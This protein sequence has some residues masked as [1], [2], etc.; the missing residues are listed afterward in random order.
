MAIVNQYNFEFEKMDFK[1]YFLHGNLEGTIYMKQY[2]GF[3]KHKSKVCLPKENQL[4]IVV[5][6][7]SQA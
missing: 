6:S 2:E 4:S 5:L 1:T 3:A 7:T